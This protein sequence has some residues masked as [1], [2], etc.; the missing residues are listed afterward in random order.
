MRHL[1]DKT[2]RI[3]F[4]RQDDDAAAAAEGEQRRA[5]A[6]KLDVDDAVQDEVD[7]EVD[8]EQKV[9]DNDRRLVSVVAGGALATGEDVKRT[10]QASEDPHELRFR[11][12][13]SICRTAP[14]GTL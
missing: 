12:S 5:C 9:G 7:G 6:S 10:A 4:I 11:V 14:R 8:Q 13:P 1:T 3:T 2:F